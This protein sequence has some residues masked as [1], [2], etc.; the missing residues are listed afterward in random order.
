MCIYYLCYKN[1]L[2]CT[3]DDHPDKAATEEAWK[4]MTNVASYINEYKRRK[5]IVSKYLDNDN[6]LIGKMWKLN[7]H[8]VAKKST[9]LSTKLSASL[10]LTNVACDTEFEELEK[11][12]RSIEKCTWQLAK[13]VEQCTTYLSD[14]AMSGDVIAEFLVHYYQGNPTLDV[15]KFQNIRSVIWSQYME[16]FKSCIEKRVNAPLHFLAT[17]LEGPAV[18]IMKRH[19]KLLDYDAAISKSE[20]YKESK[21]VIVL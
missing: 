5:D 11:Q 18:L 14:E 6:T 12:F 16:D 21:I 3:E 9:R 13:D 10:G 15:K 4:A 20:K 19:D 17:L 2:Q 8:S 7:M 1:I